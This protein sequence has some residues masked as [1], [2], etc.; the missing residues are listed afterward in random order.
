MYGEYQSGKFKHAVNNM[1]ISPVDMLIVGATGAGKSTT[2]NALFGYENSSAELSVAPD[3]RYIQDYQFSPHLRIWD[4]MGLGDGV[5]SDRAHAN[6]IISLLKKEYHQHNKAYGYIDLVLVIIEGAKRDLG[7]TYQLLDEVIAPNFPAERIIVVINQADMAMKG[8]Y[9][10][11][12]YNQPFAELKTFLDKQA[13]SIKRRIADSSQ[14]T[15]DKPIYYS[16]KYHFNIQCLLDAI[17]TKLP[18]HKRSLS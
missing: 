7:S 11:Y 18:N 14:I 5:A 2:I 17:I 9:W 12:Q 10:D 4:S 8:R 15:I 1:G 16:A 6:K 13:S 3:T